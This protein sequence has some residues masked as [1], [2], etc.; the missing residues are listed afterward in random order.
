ML[1]CLCLVCFCLSVSVLICV[2]S[3]S[4]YCV[5]FSHL[6]VTVRDKNKLWSILFNVGLLI[7]LKD[8]RFRLPYNLYCV[9]G[10]V[11][12]CKIQSNPVAQAENS[13]K[14]SAGDR[15]GLGRYGDRQHSDTDGLSLDAAAR[16]LRDV[17][18][19]PPGHHGNGTPHL[20]GIL[21][22]RLRSAAD[23]HR[24]HLNQHLSSHHHP[25]NDVVHR[26][27]R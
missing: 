7:V 12:H 3:T 14:C 16:R 23:Y 21:C 22:L 19:L 24:F 1:V 18:L 9:G 2:H 17:V 8:R 27:E 6:L 4:E 20:H 26:S 10:D 25:R 13:S 15:Y 11:K 5:A